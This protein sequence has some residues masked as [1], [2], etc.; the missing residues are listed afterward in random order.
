[1]Y[2][3]DEFGRV[4]I[5]FVDKEARRTLYSKVDY[6]CPVNVV[7]NRVIEYDMKD[8]GYSVICKYGLL[9]KVVI[10][11]LRNMDKKKR[12]ISIGMIERDMPRL[13]KNKAKGITNSRRAFMIENDLKDEDIL[14]IKNDAMFIIGKKCKHLD[15][16]EVKFAEKNTYTSYHKINNYEFYYNSRTEKLDVKGVSDKNL[17][18]FDEES[19]LKFLKTCFGY[20]ELGQSKKLK[21]FIIDY[22]HK[23]K[24]RK[25]PIGHYRP[26]NSSCEFDYILSNDTEEFGLIDMTDDQQEVDISFNFNFVIKTIIQRYL[27]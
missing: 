21:A 5:E 2:K 6:L 26:L 20:I 7:V 1:M 14:S 9:P 17:E 12:K 16:G 11:R 3:Y 13:I 15:F 24:S 27:F 18:K 25:L 22:N 23:Y 10:D 4:I 19:I 8:A